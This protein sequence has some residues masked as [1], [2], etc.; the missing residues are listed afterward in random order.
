MAKSELAIKCRSNV[1]FP[2]PL[3]DP[4][5]V[6]RIRCVEAQDYTRQKR[7]RTVMSFYIAWIKK[8][9]TKKKRLNLSYGGCARVLGGVKT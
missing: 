1:S 4:S 7:E 5:R 2:V 9:L 3:L 8:T 6:G